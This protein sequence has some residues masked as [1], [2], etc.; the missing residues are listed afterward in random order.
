MSQPL[1]KALGQSVVVENLPT[2]IELGFADFDITGALGIFAPAGTPKETV[3][4]LG[5]EIMR[6]V[7]LPEV[8]DGMARD[9]YIVNPLGPA[10][11]E[12]FLRAK[13]AQIQKIVQ[14]A[15]IKID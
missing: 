3:E 5:A 2:M 13:L 11:F 4:R 14:E 9:G 8:K 15:K 10:E 12:A 1:S 6:V 7:L